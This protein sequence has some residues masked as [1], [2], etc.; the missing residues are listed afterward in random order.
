MTDE[1][2]KAASLAIRRLTRTNE[3]GRCSLAG[4]YALGYG[5]LG[6][7]QSADADGY[8]QDW[9][10]DLD[11]LDTLFLGAIFPQEIGERYAFANARDAW[12]RALRRT[13]T[14]R[15]IERFVTEVVTAS[16]EFELPIDEGELMLLVADRLENAG[17]DQRKLPAPLQP[18]RILAEARCFTTPATGLVL[19]PA[20]ADAQTRIAR[21][22]AATE[23]D[24][25]HDGTVADALREGLH[26]LAAAGAE[27]RG[28][29]SLV[30]VLA[31]YVALVGDDDPDERAS[32]ARAWALGV[33]AD[34]PLASVVDAI[35]AGAERR[36]DIETMLG[37]LYGT[38]GFEAPVADADRRVVRLP[39]RA[40]VDIAFELGFVE[41]DTREAKIVRMGADGRGWAR[42]DGC[43]VAGLRGE[44]RPATGTGRPGV[45]RS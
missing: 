22:W 20:P 38:P 14:W 33:A 39:G 3:P 15:G 24:L 8:G 40:L 25:P 27:V 4:A 31:L 45:L 43:A 6:M 2:L 35:L 18:R 36:L 32:A 42:D 10:N 17:L 12:L 1:D 34:S 30:L 28:A 37:H 5:A 29:D 41:V 26:I 16:Q 7:A 11:P 9:Y 21:L 44:V 13:G 19:A 23:V